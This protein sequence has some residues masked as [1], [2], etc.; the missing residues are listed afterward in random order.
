LIFH[1]PSLFDLSVPSLTL[2][3]LCLRI[4][5]TLRPLMHFPFCELS[6]PLK[7][8]QRDCLFHSDYLP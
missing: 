4:S 7:V 5:L 3:P 2:L 1:F 8:R 6:F